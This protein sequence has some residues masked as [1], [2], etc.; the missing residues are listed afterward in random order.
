MDRQDYVNRIVARLGAMLDAES[1]LPCKFVIS[2]GQT[3]QSDFPITVYLEPATPCDGIFETENVFSDLQ[4]RLN[5]EFRS[6]PLYFGINVGVPYRFL[7][8]HR[9]RQHHVTQLEQDEDNN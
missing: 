7:G 1:R 8:Q 5:D 4:Q 3:I 6:D 9:L 2:G